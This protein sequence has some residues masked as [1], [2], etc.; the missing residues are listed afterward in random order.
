MNNQVLSRASDN[1]EAAVGIDEAHPIIKKETSDNGNRIGSGVD[2]RRIRWKMR[3]ANHTAVSIDSNRVTNGGCPDSTHRIIPKT[4]NSTRD[5]NDRC[6]PQRDAVCFLNTIQRTVAK[7]LAARARVVD[8][9][10]IA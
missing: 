6:T 9:K 3:S 10:K 8:Q 2:R 5:T 1:G 7:K 4:V